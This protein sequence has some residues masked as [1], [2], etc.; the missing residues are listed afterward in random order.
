METVEHLRKQVLNAIVGGRRT[1]CM[2]QRTLA[3]FKQSTI[4]DS[5]GEDVVI[6]QVSEKFIFVKQGWRPR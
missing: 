1:P 6:G 3:E 5:I 2:G 4:N